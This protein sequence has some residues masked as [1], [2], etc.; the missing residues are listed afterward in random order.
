MAWICP[1]CNKPD[2]VAYIVNDRGLH[3]FPCLHCNKACQTAGYKNGKA[4]GGHPCRDPRCLGWVYDVYHF[5]MNGRLSN[6][7][8]Q[9]CSACKQLHP[10]EVQHGSGPGE[11]AV[12][13]AGMLRVRGG[14]LGDGRER[15]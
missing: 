1:H 13:H 6:V 14:H 9:P 8:R 10:M 3:P 5:D 12:P 4:A 15:Q 2:A 11:Q 7:V